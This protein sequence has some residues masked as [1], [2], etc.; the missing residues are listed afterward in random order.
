MATLVANDNPRP[1]P[2][3]QIHNCE[4]I[5]S[6]SYRLAGKLEEAKE[7]LNTMVRSTDNINEYYQRI[8][9]IHPKASP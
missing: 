7:L 5:L 8:N 4:L 1:R 9:F 2:H 3:P 6:L